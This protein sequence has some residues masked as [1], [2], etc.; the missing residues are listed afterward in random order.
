MQTGDQVHVSGNLC[1]YFFLVFEDGQFPE[2]QFCQDASQYGKHG[3]GNGTGNG[4]LTN[5]KGLYRVESK[6]IPPMLERGTGMRVLADMFVE[7]ALCSTALSV[8]Y[9]R[10]MRT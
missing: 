4:W 2:H 5:V 9:I 1:L 7:Y 8:G 10:S 6:N 3:I